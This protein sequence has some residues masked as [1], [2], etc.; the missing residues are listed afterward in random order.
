MSKRAPRRA[1]QRRTGRAIVD[2]LLDA[3][4]TL[5]A[6]EGLAGMTTNAVATRAGVSVGSLY[7]YF[8][9][10]QALVAAVA[11]RV[12][13]GLVTEVERIVLSDRSP[14]AKLDA[15]VGLLCASDVADRAV[16]RALLR[17]VPRGWWE[18]GIESSERRVAEHLVPLAR[19]LRPALD[20]D[21]ARRRAVLAL[22]ALR[23]AVQGAL[24]YGPEQLDQPAM[25]ERLRALALTALD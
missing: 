10:K 15:L 7:Q 16:R 14:T 9:N 5:L 18:S 21:E 24:V 11:D 3:A 4:A 8:P 13:A 20:D 25:R 6:T 1:P 2:A 17:D 19:A 12:N 23:G 22:F